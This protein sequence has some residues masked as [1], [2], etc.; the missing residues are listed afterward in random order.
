MS[1]ASDQGAA[2]HVCIATGQN[3][4]NLIP[5]LQYDAKEVWILQTPAMREAAG[6]LAR[7][8]GQKQK[9]K[10]A[11]KDFDDSSPAQVRASAAAIA[12]ALD[13]RHVVL[14][15]TGGTKLM[16]LALRDELRMLETGGGRLDI[17]YADTSRRQVDWLGQDPRTEPMDDVVD[18]SRMLLV[19]GYRIDGDSRHAEAQRRAQP[20][21][22]LTRELGEKAGRYGRAF[23][24]LAAMAD[25]A[26]DSNHERDLTQE[27]HYPPGGAFADILDAGQA[28]G[29]L[30]LHGDEA[31][32]FAS[33]EAAR[34][35]AGGW[36]EEYVLLKL[37][38]GL[39]TPGR[40]ACNLKV[41]SSGGVENEV[42]AMIMHRNRAL[43]VECKTGKQDEPSSAL[44][45]LAQLRDRLGGSVA[46]ALYLSAQP[47]ANEHLRRAE[48]YR[49]HV[50]CAEQVGRFAA[51]V[52]EWKER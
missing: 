42:D 30:R 50:L 17:L 5:L 34:Y 7:A 43:F 15:A 23:S 14:H 12:E 13:G 31:V 38:G 45:K 47:L 6:N 19:Q 2:V 4:A 48:E 26:A 16:V 21:A 24:A 35:F 11:R 37:V 10:I 32:T 18:V 9:R 49:I 27:F 39:S 22:R 51:W 8:L 3:A 33:K 25:K 1:N 46:A 44:Y 41:L 29:L 28:Q 20:R 52:R 36:L 40:F